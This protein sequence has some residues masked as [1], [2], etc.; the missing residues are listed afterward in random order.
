MQ[1]FFIFSYPKLRLINKIHLIPEYSPW[2]KGAV[3]NS[4]KLIRHYI[5]KKTNFYLLNNLEIKQ[6]QY[7]INN[8]PRKKLNFYSPKEIFF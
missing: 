2:E 3:E 6:I 1:P 8:R 4:N 7:K 5:P